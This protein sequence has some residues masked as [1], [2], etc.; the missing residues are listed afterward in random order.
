MSIWIRKF[1]KTLTNG[2]Q[3]DTIGSGLK[4]W[5][6]LTPFLGGDQGTIRVVSALEMYYKSSQIV[7]S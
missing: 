1:T 7:L 5:Q 6:R 4:V 2:T 3:V